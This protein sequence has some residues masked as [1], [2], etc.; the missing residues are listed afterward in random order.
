MSSFIG[1][2]SPFGEIRIFNVYL[3][4]SFQSRF[5]FSGETTEEEQKLIFYLKYNDK[6]QIISYTTIKEMLRFILPAGR[7]NG[8]FG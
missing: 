6:A 4:S 8:G 7:R 1:A 3:S 5:N 2:K